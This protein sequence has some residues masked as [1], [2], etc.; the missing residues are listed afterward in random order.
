[1]REGGNL[2]PSGLR[3]AKVPVITLAIAIAIAAIIFP[4]IACFAA[5]GPKL[6]SRRDESLLL[7]AEERFPN[8]THAER[9][10]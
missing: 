8:L 6:K 5:S 2:I 1:M 4:Q 9:D 7:L 10:A 3:Y